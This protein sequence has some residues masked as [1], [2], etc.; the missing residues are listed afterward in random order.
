MT[1]TNFSCAVKLAERTHVRVKYTSLKFSLFD[2]L[3]AF[4]RNLAEYDATY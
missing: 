4:S 2:H 1:S 3:L